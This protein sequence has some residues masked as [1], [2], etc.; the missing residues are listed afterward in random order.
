[1]P[2]LPET[3]DR[4]GAQTPYEV[5]DVP[6]DADAKTLRDRREERR[7]DLNEA[8]LSPTERARQTQRLEAAY[9]QVCGPNR[10]RVDFFLLDPN[11]GR[12]QCEVLARTLSKPNTEIQGIVKPR[13]FRVG[14][15]VVLGE[16]DTFVHEPPRVVG[17]HP[18]PMTLPGLD[19]PEPLAV[20]FDC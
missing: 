2:D 5:L 3:L 7:H 13:H 20:A 12:K 9:N 16:L 4:Y 17:L 11:L 18:Q 14:Y 1:M 8:S 10:V 6:P 19:L 15:A